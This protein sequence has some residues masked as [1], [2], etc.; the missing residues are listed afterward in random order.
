M[1]KTLKA[2][3]NGEV[4]PKKRRRVKIKHGEV[5]EQGVYTGPPFK[6]RLKELDEQYPFD[7]D[8]IYERQ[9]DGSFKRLWFRGLH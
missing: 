5:D 4:L 2:E 6:E 1:K 9:E 3:S 7:N 8:W